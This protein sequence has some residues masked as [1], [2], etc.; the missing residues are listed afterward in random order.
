MNLSLTLSKTEQ[1]I[2][3]KTH[4]V[5]VLSFWV[6]C[7]VKVS[8]MC[9]ELNNCWREENLEGMLLLGCISLQWQEYYLS[10]MINALVYYKKAP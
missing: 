1:H 7:D 8:Y 2:M 9:I 3:K 4:K 10:E 6:E 5:T